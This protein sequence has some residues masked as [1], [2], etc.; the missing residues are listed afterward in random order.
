MEL[1]KNTKI[2]IVDDHPVFRAGIKI[3]LDFAPSVK[4]IGETGDG[5]EAVKLA[6]EL[7]PDVILLDITL[8]S[9]S[10]LLVAKEILVDIP[11]VKIIFLTMHKEEDIFNAAFQ[12]GATAFILK[13]DAM[14]EI[15][16][17]IIAVI[18]GKKYVSQSMKE[19]VI[20]IINKKNYSDLLKIEKL[21]PKE[22]EILNLIGEAKTSKEISELLFCS[23]K[24]VENHRSNICSK[25]N[26]SGN[27]ALMKFAIT[28]RQLI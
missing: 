11:S 7:L 3:A 17:A 24:T 1:M 23:I 13:D 14:G 22:R 5:D 8:K 28:Y 27:N 6:K 2:L 19:Y 12:L 15:S 21:T 4:I 10:G 26:L 16:E 9:K 25:F 20:P 18:N